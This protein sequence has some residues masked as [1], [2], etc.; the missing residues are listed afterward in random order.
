MATKTKKPVKKPSLEAMR[1]QVL[2]GLAMP[3][4]P[5]RRVPEVYEKALSG[6]DEEIDEKFAEIT[7]Q[8]AFTLGFEN[9]YTLTETVDYKYRGMAIELRRQI[10]KDFDCKTYTEKVLVDSIW[11]DPHLL[12]TVVNP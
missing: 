9:D 6:A 7:E 3:D 10:V 2:R 12:D 8:V 5:K 4:D 1:K 11:C